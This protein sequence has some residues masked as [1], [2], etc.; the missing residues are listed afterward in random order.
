MIVLK[1][2]VYL[3]APVNGPY[4]WNTRIFVL[5]CTQRLLQQ[6]VRYN[7]SLN[8]LKCVN[9]FKLFEAINNFFDCSQRK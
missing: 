8:I 9:S 1:G 6:C 2:S 5:I 7:F 4:V 3:V